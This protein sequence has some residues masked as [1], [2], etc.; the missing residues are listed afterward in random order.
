MTAK[1]GISY[2]EYAL[3]VSIVSV[4]VAVAAIFFGD[5]LKGLF[6][7]NDTPLENLAQAPLHEGSQF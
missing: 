1:K 5:D 2:R 3:L 7:P 4:F 6:G